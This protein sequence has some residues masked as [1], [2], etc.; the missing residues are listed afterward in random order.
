[1]STLAQTGRPP[2]EPSDAS[3]PV[4]SSPCSSPTRSNIE[5]LILCY[6]EAV[7]LPHALASVKD[8]ADAV[9]VIDSGSND[10]SQEIARAA[11]AEVV[12]RPW[13]GYAR[14]KNWALENVPLRADW[15]FILDADESITPELRDELLSIS[16]E[17]V[18][19]ASDTGY[20][21]N[22]LTYFMGRPIR[23][24]GYFP[25]YNL[26]FFRRGSARYEDREVHEHMVVEG[27]TSRLRHMMLHE[28]RRGLEHFIA[29]HNRYS[30]LEA[31]ELVKD[32]R[33]AQ[34]SMAQELERGIAIR[35][36]LKRNVLPRLPLSGVWRFIY[37]YF[38]RLG[39][40]DGA[41]GLRFCL[42]LATYD[43]FITLKLVELRLSLKEGRESAMATPAA[44]G[45]AVEEGS[46]K[47]AAPLDTFADTVGTGRSDATTAP[48][49]ARPTPAAESAPA[50]SGGASPSAATPAP[51]PAAQPTPAARPA[52]AVR[53]TFVPESPSAFE[54][55]WPGRPAAFKPGELVQRIASDGHWSF[56]RQDAAA[57]PH[58]PVS[59]VILAFNEEANI[60]PC[61][62]SCSWC[63]DVHVLDS[64]SGDRTREVAE[65]YGATVHVNPFRSFGQQRNWAIDNI[66][67][68]HRWQ[69][70]IDAD[71]RF[72]PA[73]VAEM[74]ARIRPDGSS[75]DGATAYQ[76]PSKLMFMDRWVRH[77]AEFPVYQVRLIDKAACRFEDHGHG[78]REVNTGATGVMIQPYLHYNFSKGLEEWIEKHNRYSTLE[79]TQALAQSGAGLRE[80]MADLFVRGA[81]QRRRALK[82]L[83]WRL[84]MRPA[85]IML[86][87]LV[88]RRGL[89]DG[90]VGWNYVRL[91]AIYES[92]TAVKLAVLKHQAADQ[93]KHGA[94]GTSQTNQERT[95]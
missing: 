8:W 60:G 80:S 26:R 10:G 70:Q 21:V 64:G 72:T 17:P 39:F 42:F 81:V 93:R 1:M 57:M 13:L 74:H 51:G 49:E 95:P 25:S 19:Q 86:Y 55:R 14:Q 89:L 54:T 63:D 76:N 67:T 11:G 87:Q 6:N 52:P 45:L 20:Y 83:S 66:P 73:V 18:A 3:A 48:A 43:F 5:V 77:A 90:A 35:R 44:R 58:V 38:F 34:G 46:I 69:F 28:D 15:V 12:H 65:R 9:H 33:R 75:S 27:T 2:G 62:E 41:T 68:K 4:G 85:L 16:R 82:R 32:Q 84:P 37:M 94:T 78:Q 40:L 30:T 22:R 56:S 24:A 23:H 91:R 92:M 61:L 88:L 71:E 7:N 31:R 36:W 47:S 53:P 50:P 79:A 59:V 29:K